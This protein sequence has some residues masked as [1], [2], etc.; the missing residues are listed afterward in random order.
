M[1][2]SKQ[3]KIMVL[4]S[5]KELTDTIVVIDNLSTHDMLKA[6]VCYTLLPTGAT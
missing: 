6:I 4:D 1:D 5:I 2:I 3:E